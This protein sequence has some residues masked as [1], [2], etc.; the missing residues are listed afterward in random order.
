MGGGKRLH[1]KEIL[2]TDWIK[3]PLF[4]DYVINQE[5]KL[6]KFKDPSIG[7]LAPAQIQQM[8]KI[9]ITISNKT[10]ISQQIK[11]TAQVLLKELIPFD[12]HQEQPLFQLE[13]TKFL[14]VNMSQIENLNKQLDKL[15]KYFRVRNEL[16]NVLSSINGCQE[17]H[18]D[19]V[20][21]LHLYKKA[22]GDDSDV[23][24]A[25]D[26]GAAY[27]LLKKIKVY[28]KAGNIAL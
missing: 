10:I 2:K 1:L 7:T 25:L 11:A 21:I 14:Q 13:L 12:D 26:E 23:L 8:D 15:Q 24:G 3:S 22:S 5:D 27:N 6:Y 19:M 28:Q 17:M 16:I 4:T 9:Q 18:T 20:Q